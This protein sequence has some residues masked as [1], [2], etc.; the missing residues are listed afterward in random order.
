M[1]SRICVNSDVDIATAPQLE[2]ALNLLRDKSVVV[3]DLERCPYF[4]S[5]GIAVLY[6]VIRHHYVIVYMSKECLIHRLFDIVD[7]S[8]IFPIYETETEALNAALRIARTTEERPTDK[9][10]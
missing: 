7:G 6:K 3:A 5:S 4:D 9:L 1:G 8:K 2:S 10:A